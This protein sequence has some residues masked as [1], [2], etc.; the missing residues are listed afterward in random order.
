MRVSLKA[1]VFGIRVSQCRFRF[2]LRAIQIACCLLIASIA[3]ASNPIFQ[4]SF[5]N[6]ARDWTA[7]RGTA[8][9]DTS[10]MHD[11]SP[12]LRVERDAAAQDACVRLAPI[13]LVLGKRYELT[14]WIRTE[15]LEVRDLDRSPIAVG[16]TLTMASMPFDVHS[17][18]LGGTQLWT[19]VK[20]DFVASRTQDVVHHVQRLRVVHHPINGGDHSH[21]SAPFF[22]T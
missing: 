17:A 16:A 19:R 22:H 3:Q 21:S 11:K 1:T 18:S 9:L 8:T 13:T 4:T 12:S 15:G 20:L 2:V 5:Q 7:E 6:R 14:G 10:V